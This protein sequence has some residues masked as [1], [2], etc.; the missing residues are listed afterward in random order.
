VVAKAAATSM[1]WP[2]PVMLRSCS[3]ARMAITAAENRGDV[4]H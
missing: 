4:W 3:A 2:R 1:Y